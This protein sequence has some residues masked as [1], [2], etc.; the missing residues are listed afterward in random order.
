M[1]K[2]IYLFLIAIVLPLMQLMANITTN[3]MSVPPVGVVSY[4]A[5]TQIVCP[6]NATSFPMSIDVP[7]KVTGFNKIINTKGTISWDTSI[8]KYSYIS[9]NG[10]SASGIN[11]FNTSPSGYLTFNWNDP[12]LKG[13]SIADSSLFFTIRFTIAGT[14]GNVSPITLSNNPVAYISQDSTLK[15]IPTYTVNGSV[16][17]TTGSNVNIGSALTFC[18][19]DSALLTSSTGTTYQWYYNGN[20]V[21]NANNQ[22]FHAYN[23]GTYFVLTTLPNGCNTYSN[24]ISLTAIPAPSSPVITGNT[25]T[26]LCTGGSIV[27][28]CSSGNS[29]Q[30]YLNGIAISGGNSQSYTASSSGNYTV[31]TT[32]TSGCKSPASSPSIITINNTPSTPV[33]SS[34]G[35]TSF[36]NS[37][38]DTLVCSSGSGYQ[39]YLNG[40]MINAANSQMLIIN[41]SGIYSATTANGNC[42]SAQSNTVT[43]NVTS[44]NQP[45]IN[46]SGSSNLCPGSSVILSSNTVYSYY[47][48][49][50]N[51]VPVNGANNQS[52]TAFSAGNYTLLAGVLGSCTLISNPVTISGVSV[53][54]PTIS[55]SGTTTFCSGGSV[56]LTCNNNSYNTYQWLL[57][58]NNIS[59]ATGQTYSAT[60]TGIYTVNITNSAGCS[61]GSASGVTITVNSLP[62]IPTITVIGST[63][64]CS[65]ANLTL[66][67]SASGSYQWYNNGITIS[68]AITQSNVVT[69]AGN[70]TVSVT[71]SYGCLATSQPVVVT[72]IPKTTPVITTSG[73][74][75]FCQ[76]SNVQLNATNGYS[77]YKWYLNNILIN[78]ASSAVYLANTTGTYTVIGT[79]SDGCITNTS[80]ATNVTVYNT[81]AIPVLNSN[82]ST[83]I[84]SG[85]NLILNSTVE[86]AYSWYLNGS[87]FNT[88]NNPSISISNAG[89]Y[90]VITTNA[91]GC[92]SS[93]SNTINVT[94][95]TP[96]TPVITATGNTTIC[97]GDSVLLTTTLGNSYQWYLNGSKLNN[98]N[99][100]SI[101]ATSNGGY[102]ASVTYPGGCSATSAILNISV[103]TSPAPVIT[104]KNTIICQGSNLTLSATTGYNKYQWFIGGV[105]ISGATSSTYTT[106]V[107]GNYTVT[108]TSSYGC[109]SSQSLPVTITISSLPSTPV[110]T[111]TGSTSFCPGSS[112]I[113]TSSVNTNN[114]YQWYLNGNILNSVISQ[115]CIAN[116]AGVYTVSIT[117]S[118]GCISNNSSPVNVIIYPVANIPVIYSST[119]SDTICS[120]S[121]IILS[122]SLQN[123]YQ[124]YQNGV[125]ITGA[126]GQNITV[127]AAGNYAVNITN[128]LGCSATSVLTPVIVIPK[129]TPVI[130]ATGNTSF[131]P[132]NTVLLN[133]S[134]YYTYQWY[135]NG[136]AI[137]GATGST[138]V[139]DSAGNYTVQGTTY[140]GCI[141]YLS[142][143]VNVTVYST[144]PTPV[145]SATS[146]TICSGNSTTLNSTTGYSYLW[147]SNG[148]LQNTTSSSA[149]TVSSAG[150]YSVVTTNQYSCK[151][152]ASNSIIINVITPSTP[153]VTVSG[154]TT[155]CSGDSVLLTSSFGNTYQWFLNGIKLINKNTQ[156]IFVSASGNYTVSVT[157]SSGCSATS[158]S[159]N[160][161]VNTNP[162]PSVSYSNTVICQGS[163]LSLSA[164]AGYN[165]YQWYIG[166][167]PVT[168]AT[169]ATYSASVADSYTVTGINSYGCTSVQSLP[170]SLTVSSLPVKP[171]ISNTGST[172]FCPGGS[173]ILTSSVNP[174][175]N[176]QWYLNGNLLTGATGQ[177][178]T[179]TNAGLYNVITTNN[180]G[181]SSVGSNPVS[182]IIYPA[183]TTPVIYSSTGSDSLCYGSNIILSTSL[184]SSYQ[185]YQNGVAIT[186]STAQYC[187]VNAAGNYSVNITNNQ[188]C[189]ASSVIIPVTVISKS[190]PVITAS[191][192][193][194]F[195]PGSSVQLNTNGYYT[196]Q[197]YLNG[198][199]ITGANASS[200]V[201]DTAGSYTVQGTTY[202]GCVSFISSPVNVTVYNVPATPV[203]SALNSSICA[204]NSTSLSSTNGATYLWYLNGNLINTSTN[205][206]NTISVAGTY[207]VVTTN[208]YGCMS[209]FSNQ[210]NI[211]IITPAIPSISASGNTSICSGDSVALTSGVASSYQWYYNGTLIPNTN[212]QNYFASVSGSYYV[213]VTYASGCSAVSS[214]VSV[215]TN[216]SATPVITYNQSFI[217]PSASVL[218]T[219]SQGYNNYQ[220]YFNNNVIP[221]AGNASYNA[222]TI[223][224]YT[225]IGYNLS[226]CKSTPSIPATLS[227]STT[228]PTPVITAGKYT[229][230][231]GDTVILTST[232]GYSY[233]WY[234]N[235]YSISGSG[236][237]SI[238]V[239]QPGNYYVV[240]TNASGCSSS[241]SAITTLQQ[242]PTSIP[243]I[244]ASGP[245]NICA[246]YTV[247]LTSSLANTYQWY[248][249]NI[250]VSGSVNSTYNAGSTG[251]YYVRETDI[252]GCKTYSNTISVIVDTILPPVI[253][254][255]MSGNTNICS[256]DSTILMANTGYAYYQWYM[257]GVLIP[258]ANTYSISVKNTGSYTATGTSYS[259][260]ISPASSPVQINAYSIPAQ[261]VIT[262]PTNSLCNGSSIILSGNTIA[263][264]Y[265]WYLNGNAI[266]G[267]NSQTY[268]VFS[269]GT[270][271]LIVS[272][273]AG[274][275][276]VMSGN[277][278]VTNNS[279]I[280]VI[281]SNGSTILCSG[282]S[283]TL[284]ASAGTNYQWYNNGNLISSAN[285]Q[286]YTTSLGGNYTVTVTNNYNCSSTSSA[287]AVTVNTVI[288]PVL[289]SSATTVCK[290]NNITLTASQ[291]YAYYQWYNNG[292]VIPGITTISYTASVSGNYTVTGTTS[293]GCT[294]PASLPVPVYIFTA[295]PVPVITTLNSNVCLGNSATL[296]SSIGISYQWYLNG[297]PIA[298][299]T[300]Q[301]YTT[302]TQG[303]YAVIITDTNGCKST[304]SA[305][306]PVNVLAVPAIPAI[307]ASGSTTICTG[308]SITLTS[309]IATAYQWYLNG[310]AITGAITQTLNVSS[311]GYYSV[312]V[313][314]SNNCSAVSVSTPVLISSGRTPTVTASGPT[315]FC[316]GGSVILTAAADSGYTVYQWYNNGTIIN[317]A[318]GKTF[319][320]NNSGSY[321][322]VA[323][324]PGGCST[325][326]SLATIVT[327]N[328]VPAIP[329]I[330]PSGRAALCKNSVLSLSGP[331]ATSYQ[332]YKNGVAITG[333]INQTYS[334]SDSGTYS[335]QVY[336]TGGCGISS[337]TGTKVWID[338]NTVTIAAVSKTLFCKGDSVILTAGL[339]YAYQWLINSTIITNAVKQNYTVKSSGNYSVYATDSNN[340]SSGSGTVS[341]SVVTS[342]APLVIVNGAVTFCSGSYNTTL[343]AAPGLS[344]YQWYKNDTL[345]NGA[346][347]ISYTPTSTGNYT[348]VANNA[349]SCQSLPSAAVG[350]TVIQT[351]VKPLVS[352]TN[353]STICNGN[354]I[355]LISS[356]GSG[357]QWYR[358][359]VLLVGATSQTYNATN[360]GYYS[361]QNINY[362]CVSTLS[363]SFIIQKTVNPG[364]TVNNISQ[365]LCTNNFDFISTYP[366]SVNKYYWDFGDGYSDTAINPVHVYNQM[367]SYTVRQVITSS[368]NNCIDSA[369]QSVTVTQCTYAGVSE[370]DSV[371]IYPNPNR[372]VFKVT[373]LSIAQRHAR[374]AVIGAETGKIY[375]I[376]DVLAVVGKNTY[377]FD[378]SAPMYKSGTYVIRV[379]GD[380]IT[381]TVKKFVLIR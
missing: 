366:S 168:G 95:T 1:K 261:P 111:S 295:A 70:Y 107:A 245:T 6:L 87:L 376:K 235:G 149:Y 362:G 185:W 54:N 62:N 360:T 209:A 355:L 154:N 28:T 230:C 118:V 109:N 343:N 22:S 340:C 194:S 52:Y 223:G 24:N 160:I 293:A 29:Y 167:N 242:Y 135:L 350:V 134:G 55:T 233:Q 259:G 262:A 222:T 114:T 116:T 220:W 204:G 142:S 61:A 64:L 294:S 333:A 280:P 218:L 285:T 278:I 274:C 356:S 106:T 196:C 375:M 346:T 7:I 240:I 325:S 144:P 179:A 321:T 298:Y 33:I 308:N 35:S 229:F 155:I 319:T 311:A 345:I 377:S 147:Y 267:A 329:V 357:Y 86:Y 251:S 51:N 136:I 300:T 4:F 128:S 193:T 228:P 151:S 176:Y 91:N 2:N 3:R 201:A 341:I 256:G 195:C 327:A 255:A 26:T 216:I 318:T 19:G 80:S 152:S 288:T 44:I 337:S 317:G 170:V 183:A 78:N 73:N 182:V 361:V 98:T 381:Y 225:V 10:S 76:G 8:I 243:V 291:G 186:G 313:F 27:L 286:S 38:F 169:N 11:T 281:S 127:N 162:A 296:T 292:I 335:L 226:G 331:I 104:Y 323:T 284:I 207:S 349:G 241:A 289:T 231:N 93:V 110:I 50:L 373:F 332:W 85:N 273:L 23:S 219:A 244:N 101:Y 187:I 208:M 81:P 74:T 253:A 89:A 263:G 71:N 126:T 130:S 156:N 180:S 339:G 277:F 199:A 282:A 21:Q 270:Y 18:Q 97:S 37:S 30:W 184:Q 119:G 338:T 266:I 320:V 250:P 79:T 368:N 257:N 150:T 20:P 326:P 202:G 42:V 348:L 312:Q 260:C 302:T 46:L 113:L 125:A 271:S 351:P 276:S 69:T 275:S 191:G 9:N 254:I 249:N 227:M 165:S 53:I 132:G 68:S 57:N 359:G 283:A 84:C 315:V 324:I 72:V 265:Q 374:I 189:T 363:D 141:S 213:S 164:T 177:Y 358:N 221:G 367:G 146:S 197:W 347:G 316:N 36:C 236:S 188:G 82:G 15:I 239:T 145:L 203:L 47:Q 161:I 102:S 105:N 353:G 129:T 287:I 40:N 344:Y 5:T 224:N 124:W 290:G 304:I 67:S 364:F 41:N 211:N 25:G 336:N 352:S 137:T 16:V 342:P 99:T 158:G 248:L 212:K 190:T 173:V 138:Y 238:A 305:A 299:A 34:K 121:T 372:G 272:N 309:A 380:N 139:A 247:S 94:V 217:C 306:V 103:Y 31:I 66:I 181:C 369:K 205:P 122:T 88:T 234:F 140:G 14:F 198:V 13:V 214:A 171:V 210:I 301:S 90:T 12:T 246:G 133:T 131:C 279:T 365:Q 117:N 45:V 60:S 297:N 56:L 112:L 120:G 334:A 166:G 192:N 371:N 163:N 237:N 379:I 252:N 378:L 322:V 354:N 17:L 100:Q 92:N 264:S 307:T 330:T 175:N 63:N 123:S 174:N 269:G 59:N 200:F 172:S 83:T 153:L 75:S 258:G 268:T 43:I 108:G 310:T 215:T 206:L 49:Y 232:S 48:W 115:S 159:V 65:G 303:N 178:Y 77:S 96:A 157:Y 314:N 148:I 32:N 58:G 370:Q 328:T 39:W 143:P